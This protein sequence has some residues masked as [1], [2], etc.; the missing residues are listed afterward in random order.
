[1]NKF[2]D[3]PEERPVI[4]RSLLLFFLCFQLLLSLSVRADAGD[5]LV[6]DDKIL[7]D[8]LIYPDWFKDHFGHLGEAL[9]EARKAGKKGIIVYYGQKR[10]AYCRQFL[11]LDLGQPDIEKYIRDNFDV[12]PVDNKQ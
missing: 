4:Q 7:E 2:S 9:T 11:Q 12:V 5:P 3:L 8:E 10:C 6:F 1:M